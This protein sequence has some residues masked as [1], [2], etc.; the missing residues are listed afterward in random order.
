M[1]ILFK[2]F[3]IGPAAVLRYCATVLGQPAD[4]ASTHKEK[5]LTET[6]AI[7]FPNLYVR[8]TM[9]GISILLFS[10]LAFLLNEKRKHADKNAGL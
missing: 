2:L 3:V 9:L 7:I 6:A 4:S 8:L 1:G 10:G 5:V